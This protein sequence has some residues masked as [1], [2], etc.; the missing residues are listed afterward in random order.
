MNNEQQLV[1]STPK[2]DLLKHA[3]MYRAPVVT[4]DYNILVPYQ[5]LED[6]LKDWA[7][8]LCLHVIVELNI[9]VCVCLSGIKPRSCP[10]FESPE[11]LLIPVGVEIP[12]SFEGRNLDIYMVRSVRPAH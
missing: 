6:D 8:L 5:S 12:I 1:I 10:Q 4:I 2:T 7:V 3:V 11:P 9:S